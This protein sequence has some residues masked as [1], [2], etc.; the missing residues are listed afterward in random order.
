MKN[1]EKS[2]RLYIVG[3]VI[4][5]LVILLLF[6]TTTSPVLP[7]SIGVDSA[8]FKTVGRAW[9]EG[10]L[11]YVEAWDLK[12]PIV[13]LVNAFSYFF[14]QNDVGVF[15]LQALALSVS[16]LIVYYWCLRFSS[17]KTSFLFTCLFLC[18]FVFSYEGGNC[19]EEYCLPF[20]LGGFYCA[21]RW[22]ERVKLH[23]FDHP[24]AYSFVYGMAVGVC[25]ATRLTNAMGLCAV[26]AYIGI[27]LLAKGRYKNVL[28]NFVALFVGFGV[29]VLP[30]VCYFYLHDAVEEL[31]YGTIG[32]NL[33]Y[34]GNPI[35]KYTPMQLLFGFTRTLTAPLYTL[36]VSSL[37]ILLF[38]RREARLG[39]MGLLAALP[40]YAW[41]THGNSYLHYGILALAST[42]FTFFLI[43]DIGKKERHWIGKA[44]A[45][46]FLLLMF[47]AF[48]YRGVADRLPHL[49]ALVHPTHSVVPAADTATISYQEE[50]EWILQHLPTESR[51]AVI[52]Y[53]IHPIV[54][55]Q[56]RLLPCYPYFALQEAQ[57]RVSQSFRERVKHAFATCKAEYI[58]VEGQTSLIDHTLQQ[59]YTLSASQQFEKSGSSLRL[60]QRKREA[61]IHGQ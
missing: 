29:V 56:T 3:G 25:A 35:G 58:V 1:R 12:G 17:S 31:W 59:H 2:N 4:L 24:L 45:S 61:P 16:S 9:A 5:S 13:F 18:A 30:F 22:H 50:G 52:L 10:H 26:V 49:L 40:L 34:L 28:Q 44:L 6:S 57:G 27:Y 47:T 54:Y 46:S 21:Y 55:E 19:V 37:F 53:G 8:I 20:L 41:F 7:H 43:H 11:P 38:W 14:F 33:D 32:F 60:Y 48:V 36:I 23:Q 39:V 42:P 51:N 15:L